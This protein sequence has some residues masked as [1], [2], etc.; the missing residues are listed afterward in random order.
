MCTFRAGSES[1][2]CYAKKDREAVKENK[3]QGFAGINILL[4]LGQKPNSCELLGV[5]KAGPD[6]G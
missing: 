1:G 6:H 2:Q 5:T 3:T 4:L